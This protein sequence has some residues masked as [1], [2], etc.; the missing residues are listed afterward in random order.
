MIARFLFMF[1][2]DG[3]DQAT[4]DKFNALARIELEEIRDFLVLHYTA[5]ERDD[6]PF[7][8]HC[9]AIAEA[10]FAAAALG[11][12][13]AAAA[14]SSSRPAMLFKE[15]ELVRHLQRTG[16]ASAQPITRSPTFRRDAELARR[17]DAA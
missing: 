4:I 15:A 6:T 3:F 2:G 7:W 16:P 12:V 10:R 13:R 17:F 14:T 5:T 9:R 1:P 11:H 8:R